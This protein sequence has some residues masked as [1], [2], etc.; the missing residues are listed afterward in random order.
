VRTT[1]SIIEELRKNRDERLAGGEQVD[2]SAVEQ[3]I[4]A[5][6]ELARLRER[7]AAAL[8][9]KDWVLANDLGAQ[10]QHWLRFVSEDVDEKVADDPKKNATSL[11]TAPPADDSVK[12]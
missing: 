9:A 11:V 2:V 12:G 8:K 6:Q 4:I 7:R 5:H 3:E 10:I 1:D